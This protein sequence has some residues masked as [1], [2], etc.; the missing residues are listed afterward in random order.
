LGREILADLGHILENA[1]YFEL[2]A[3]MKLKDR[4]PKTVICFD[5]EEPTYN[6]IVQRNATKWLL[7]LRDVQ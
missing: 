6:G 2:S 5:P 1:V 3:F 7:N 4:H